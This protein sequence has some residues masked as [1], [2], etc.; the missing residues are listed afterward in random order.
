MTGAAGAVRYG[1]DDRLPPLE[2][3]LNALQH[4]A[5]IAPVGLVFPALVAAAAHLPADDAE[6]VIAAS[7]IALGA[8]SI[9]L[10]R[11]GRWS[12]AGFLA[13]SI[14]TAAYLP[15]C[16]AAAAVG[17]MPL[18]AGMTIFAGLC[19]IG[20]SFVLHRWRRLL[21]VEISGLA[22][23]MIGLTLAL[24]GFEL[25][26][27]VEPGGP[28]P[29]EPAQVEVWIL[30]L[31]S[32]ACIVALNVWGRGPVRTFAVLVGVTAGYAAAAV[33]GMVDRAGLGVDLT[34]PLVELPRL[35]LVLPTF[36]AAL[37]PHFVIG[38]LAS[39]LR[40]MG[41]I[42]TCQRLTDRR[43]VRPDFDSIERGVRAD[44]LS[45][46][47]AG[48]LGS[49]G[50]N[51]FSGSIGLSQASGV[52][53]RQVGAAVGALFVL[54][55]FCPPVVALAAAMPRPVT[56][57][58][59]LFSSTFILAN[60]L[61]IIVAR[62]LDA[63]RILTIGLGTFFGISHAAFLGFYATLPSWLGAVAGSALML[64]LVIALALNAVFRIGAT[65]TV[66]MA[67]PVDPDLPQRIHALCEEGGAAAGARRDVVD[68][69]FSAAMEA[70]EIALD[71]P[72]PGATFAL[73]LGFDEYFVDATAAFE[74]SGAVAADTPGDGDLPVPLADLAM[75]LIRRQADRVT[76]TTENGRTVLRMRFDA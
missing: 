68:R 52:L 14:F 75:L 2:L 43:W 39:A 26:F 53:A 19:E 10:C 37:A 50:L 4:V 45:T 70:A 32:L 5:V 49:V 8:G 61:Q 38:A 69:V 65:R 76:E 62:L 11:A 44:G 54:L 33:A 60:G 15:G 35:L 31:G 1:R 28:F 34:G 22:V 20:W 29:S 27:A 24:L 6:A 23:V 41:D 9:L 42:T 18:V 74:R 57:A 36:D 25:V 12:G 7:L 16:L 21:P 55:A 51:T 71:A 66:R 67:V 17:G 73:T 30:G 48:A 40:A 59:L 13:P 56:G 58:V 46:I 63:R 47:V 64:S 3:L 72:R